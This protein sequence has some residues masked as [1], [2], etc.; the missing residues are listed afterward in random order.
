[1]QPGR[2]CRGGG[3]GGV[4]GGERG[5]GGGGGRVHRASRAA[6]ASRGR[7]R[8]RRHLPPQTLE[9]VEGPGVSL[10]IYLCIYLCIYL[11]Y[12][13]YLYL[14]IYLNLSIYLSVSIYRNT[15]KVVV[16]ERLRNE[17]MKP[18]VDDDLLRG[19]DSGSLSPP[20][21]EAKTDLR[22]LAEQRRVLKKVGFRCWGLGFEFHTHTHLSL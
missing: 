19:C 2:G 18:A 5:G 6:R 21:E 13:S 15:M 4:G 1:M 17:M 3:R 11:S 8:Q 7:R 9:R 10:S 14:S 22:V 12:L 20:P 16:P